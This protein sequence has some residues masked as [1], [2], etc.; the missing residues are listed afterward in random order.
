LDFLF[1]KAIE[2]AF[3][4]Y[5]RMHY[6]GGVASVYACEA[7][8]GKKA[9]AVALNSTKLNLASL[10]CFCSSSYFF[11]FQEWK[12]EINLDYSV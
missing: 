5:V 8:G 1:R 11:F 6:P 4:Q 2:I 12:V 3:N 7:E 9:V 10:W